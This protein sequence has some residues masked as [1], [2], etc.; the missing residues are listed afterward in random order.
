MICFPGAFIGE[1]RDSSFWPISVINQ[2]VTYHIQ[3]KACLHKCAV[4]TC[5]RVNRKFVPS[6][7]SYLFALQHAC[8]YVILSINLN[9]RVFRLGAKV[10]DVTS[11]RNGSVVLLLSLTFIYLCS[12]EYKQTVSNWLSL[13]SLA[14][15]IQKKHKVEILS[16]AS[17]QNWHIS[18]G[19]L[20]LRP[21][22]SSVSNHFVK[23]IVKW[24]NRITAI[25]WGGP[26]RFLT[27]VLI[28]FNG[29]S[30]AQS[31]NA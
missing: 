13:A 24:D 30:Q 23:N 16:A 11:K 5:L 25:S 19:T 6:V 21:T 4:N 26:E 10:C 7:C 27:T 2:I 3:E 12:K 29:H 9:S 28:A 8:D 22:F 14:R 17:N 15:G 31:A 1:G 20:C 18:K